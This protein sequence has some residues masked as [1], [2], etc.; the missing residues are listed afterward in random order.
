MWPGTS[1]HNKQCKDNVA[2]WASLFEKQVLSSV[3]KWG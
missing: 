1:M 3:V 2:V